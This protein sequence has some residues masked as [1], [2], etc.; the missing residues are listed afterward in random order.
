[1]SSS[2]SYPSHTDSIQNMNVTTIPLVQ[3]LHELNTPQHDLVQDSN[4][5]E[6]MCA[7]HIIYKLCLRYSKQSIICHLS[8]NTLFTYITDPVRLNQGKIALTRS[9]LPSTLLPTPYSL[10]DSLVPT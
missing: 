4:Y 7:Q 3:L 1:M 5:N 6:A 2:S 9:V 8:F 10:T